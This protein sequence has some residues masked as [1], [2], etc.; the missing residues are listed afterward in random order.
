M[1]FFVSYFLSYFLPYLS[2][3]FSPLVVASPSVLRPSSARARVQVSL[4]PV[5]L[6]GQVV[7]C[8]TFDFLKI[9]RST[10]ICKEHSKDEQDYLF[11]ADTFDHQ[12]SLEREI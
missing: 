7:R 2:L 5:G 8:I 6:R 10:S 3:C 4:V 9:S 12:I 11:E 1:S